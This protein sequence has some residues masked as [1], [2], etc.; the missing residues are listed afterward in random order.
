[1]NQFSLQNDYK[2]PV[3][4]HPVCFLSTFISPAKN[5]LKKLTMAI[6]VILVIL[7]QVLAFLAHLV[8]C[9]TKKQFERGAYV[10]F[11]YVGAKTFATSQK[12]FRII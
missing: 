2:E 3:K 7:G 4:N 10:V 12:K 6:L 1:M 11:E 8:P 5:R 9:P